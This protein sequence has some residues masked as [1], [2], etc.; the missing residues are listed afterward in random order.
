MKIQKIS[1]LNFGS[2]EGNNSL[3]LSVEDPAKRVVVIGGK[4]GAGKTTLFTAVQVCLYGF[5]AFGFKSEGQFYKKEIFDLINTRERLKTEGSAYVELEFSQVHET[6][7]VKYRIRRTW[8]W[9]EN[10][11]KETVSVWREDQALDVEGQLN[12]QNYLLHLI[13]PDLLKLYF[14]DGEKVSDYFLGNKQ[15]N[16]RDALMVLSG[17]DTFEIL[18]DYIKKILKLTNV[19]DSCMRDYLDA[20]KT[21]DLLSA[22]IEKLQD[23]KVELEGL[24]QEQHATKNFMTEK[25]QQAGGISVD[26][27]FQ[28]HSLIKE[29]EAKREKINASRKAWAA[30]ILP[31]VMVKDLVDKIPAQLEKEREFEGYQAIKRRLDSI[32]LRF[33]V[34]RINKALGLPNTAQSQKLIYDELVKFFEDEELQNFQPLL[35]LSRDEEALVHSTLVRLGKYRGDEFKKF[36]RALDA[37]IQRSKEFRTKINSYD[38]DQYESYVKELTKL[39]ENTKVLKAKL[40]KNEVELELKTKLHSESTSRLNKLQLELKEQLKEQSKA[41]LCSKLLLLLDEV[42]ASFYHKL[43]DNVTRDINLKFN[44]L[45]RKKDFIDLIKVD[46]S[47]NV[48]LLRRTLLAKTDLIKALKKGS[49]RKDLGEYGIEDLLEQFGAENDQA[50]IS[51]LEQASVTNV[52]VLL[53]VDKDHL[54]SGEKQIFVMSLYWAMMN[55]SKNELPYV[56]DTPFARIDAEHRSR[57][58]N[59]FFKDL[60]GQLLV[61]STDE[62]ISSE[63]IKQLKDQISNVYLLEFGLDKRTRIISNHY[64]GS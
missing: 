60:K 14:F 37:S 39:E 59:H 49:W 7:D 61:L 53:N 17:N 47:F 22:E 1:L 9:K 30:E 64:F 29:E 44:E 58:T 46:E 57:I 12:F 50:L 15:I 3:T 16:V 2:Y 11:L 27:W 48:H 41:N 21:K 45:I 23:E 8:H 35:G 32:K 54:S 13:P 36:R 24:L 62:E 38:I 56:I 28:C 18:L 33:S 6:D 20:K 10:D 55:Q 5:H 40:D 31:F 25:F 42:R 4:N 52:E 43:L 51:S 34:E 26:D 19:Q 63:H